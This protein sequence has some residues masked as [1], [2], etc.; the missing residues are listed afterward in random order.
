MNSSNIE[1]AFAIGTATATGQGPNGAVTGQQGMEM[2]ARNR[3]EIKRVRVSINGA[4]ESAKD[5]D[6]V[7]K[8]KPGDKLD[9]EVD[10]ES[11]F[12]DRDDDPDINNVDV[13]MKVDDSDLDI[14]ES[15][16]AGDIGPDEDD[17]VKF[18]T[19]DVDDDADEGRHTLTVTATGTDD[20]GARHA[21]KIEIELEVER[22]S[23]EVV[24]RRADL[25]PSRITCTTGRRASDIR[26]TAVNIGRRDEKDAAIEVNQVDFGFSDKKQDI[27]LDE[28][29]SVSRSFSINVPSTAK[30]GTYTVEV[31]AMY[32]NSIETDSKT[33]SLIV[34]NC[35]PAA[36]TSVPVTPAPV[37]TQPPV[38]TPTNTQ[39]VTPA[40]KVSETSSFTESDSYVWL[41]GGG[42]VVALAI[43]IVIVAVAFKKP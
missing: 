27:E 26:V 13:T 32:D 17:T 40:K 39:T 14:D 10:V 31:R 34:D 33:L 30:A 38:T 43:I 4:E 36:N 23:H 41:L 21:H 16:D 24:I 20:N 11:R 8:I 25:A 15:E 5:G 29:D 19:Q 6:T 12:S 2:Q 18:D 1:S 35:E 42:I 3:L 22:E 7:D 9:F 28:D 37:V